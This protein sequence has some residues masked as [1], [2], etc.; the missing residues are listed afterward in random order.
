M[1][2]CVRERARVRASA[3]GIK[4]SSIDSKA[5]RSRGL[6]QRKREA[7]RTQRK[8]CLSTVHSR[9]PPLILLTR[10]HCDARRRP[11]SSR[12]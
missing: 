5:E 10:S 7:P 12:R 2:A 4:R 1:R 6:L 8:G 9:P 3:R 11:M